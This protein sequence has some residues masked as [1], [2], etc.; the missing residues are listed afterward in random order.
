MTQGPESRLPGASVSEQELFEALLAHERDESDVI[1]AYEEFAAESA[2]DTVRYLVGLVIDD[3]KRHHRILSE[4]ANKV[5]AQA[6][7]ERVGDQV[8]E[9]DVR[10]D[11]RALLGATRRFLAVERRDRD[12]L[13]RLARR[14]RSDTGSVLDAFVVDLLRADTERHIRILRFVEHLVRQSP[15][16]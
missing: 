3:E 4:L 1:S 13:K 6:T 2:S 14:V 11:D 15:L 10:R 8:P 12:E 9:L 16:R 5:R 7:L